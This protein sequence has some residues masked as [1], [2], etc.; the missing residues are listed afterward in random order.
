LRSGYE[1]YYWVTFAD[2]RVCPDCLIIEAFQPPEGRPLAEWVAR[3]LPSAGHTVCG[4]SCRCC[5][6]EA[7]YLETAEGAELRDD[8]FV[9]IIWTEDGLAQV[10][11]TPEAVQEFKKLLFQARYAGF[12]NAELYKMLYGKTTREMNEILHAAIDRSGIEDFPE[13]G[14][15]WPKRWKLSTKYGTGYDVSNN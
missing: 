13:Y 14:L 1:L 15:V 10:G 7:P 6:V 2:G 8:K 5:L 9:S 3:G 12:N 4:G 11:V